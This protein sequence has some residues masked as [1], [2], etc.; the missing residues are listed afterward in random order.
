[1]TRELE[2]S[3]MLVTCAVCVELFEEARILSCSHSFCLHCLIGCQAQA[4]EGGA[5]VVNCPVC[6]ELTVPPL[7]DIPLLPQNLFANSVAA[8]I[9]SNDRAMRQELYGGQEEDVLEMENQ[10]YIGN[11]LPDSTQEIA[12]QSFWNK[13][14]LTATIAAVP[15][16]GFFALYCSN[17]VAII[18]SQLLA[19]FGVVN[20][21][22]FLWRGKLQH[23][24][25]YKCSN[26]CNIQSSAVKYKCGMCN[27][28]SL[29]P[30]CFAGD[31]IS[32]R[33]HIFLKLKF[34]QR[35][36]LPLGPVLKPQAFGLAEALDY[37]NRVHGRAY[38]H[39][40][41]RLHKLDG[42]KCSCCGIF[43]IRGVR[44]K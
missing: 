24:Q 37:G 34:P 40:P 15:V 12:K 28:F 32:L 39:S 29:C 14:L 23:T 41:D 27:D 17:A 35:R 18:I 2:E 44:Y 43:P 8:L 36:Q 20:S 11:L 9:R 42:I 31:D 22:Q 10:F 25:T 30:P 7:V 6:R 19:T 26:C 13:I 21:A 5:S 16:F 3:R 4:R 38:I 33:H 1:M